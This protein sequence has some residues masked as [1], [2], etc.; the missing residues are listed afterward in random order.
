MGEEVNLD[1]LDAELAKKYGYET[2]PNWWKPTRDWETAGILLERFKDW[3]I[4]RE[5]E[6][7]DCYCCT[8]DF[9][10]FNSMTVK[11]FGSG[12]QTSVPLAVSVAVAQYYGIELEEEV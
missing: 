1:R 9:N 12:P 11:T 8:I 3:N 10:K 5:D 6:E 7:E 2:P 4:S